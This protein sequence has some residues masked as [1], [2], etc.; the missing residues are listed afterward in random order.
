MKKILRYAPELYFIGL[1]IFW[2][3]ENYAAS[4]HKNYFA[5]L[6][7]W[8]MFIQIIYQ[9]RIMGFIYGN[10]IGLSSLYMMGST[11]CEFNSFKSVEVDAVLILVFGF[12]IFIPALAM[13]AGMIYKSLKSKEDYKENV[14]TITY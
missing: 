9:N 13:S 3:V 4:G 10:I 1:G 7:V 8:L 2:A 5:I 11:V 14:L 12:G 6:V